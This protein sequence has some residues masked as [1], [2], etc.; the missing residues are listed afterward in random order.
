[1]RTVMFRGTTALGLLMAG[2]V[3]GFTA[4]AAIAGNSPPIADNFQPF[5]WERPQVQGEPMTARDLGMEDRVSQVPAYKGGAAAPQS[6]HEDRADLTAYY[7][8]SPFGFVGA[9]LSL[10]NP[11]EWTHQSRGR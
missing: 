5:M 11:N 4:T 3:V 9:V 8:G 7:P 2:A 10:L 1:M 6:T